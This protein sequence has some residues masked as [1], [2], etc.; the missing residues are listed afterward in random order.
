M[1]PERLATENRLDE[2]GRARNGHAIDSEPAEE[3][4]GGAD[5][6]LDVAV[7][8]VFDAYGNVARP[9]RSVAVVGRLHVDAFPEL[10]L[11][12][13]ADVI[14]LDAVGAVGA[15]EAV[16]VVDSEDAHDLP[17]ESRVFGEIVTIS[18]EGHVSSV[19]DQVDE[20]RALPGHVVVQR[21][22]EQ[23]RPVLPADSMRALIGIHPHLPRVKVASG[24]AR[25]A[26]ELNLCLPAKIVEHV[27]G[28]QVQID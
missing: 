9:E 21:L 13:H 23:E 8:E 28:L 6:R 17:A 25:P 19:A 10:D 22:Q 27:L 3:V 5:S 16:V 4:H 2:L 11:H 1:R 15:V 7:Y 18:R 12:D 14:R 26:P 20:G 24:S